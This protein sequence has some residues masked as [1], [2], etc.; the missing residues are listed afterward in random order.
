MLC[1]VYVLYLDL[2]PE[3]M[4]ED[5]IHVVEK[6]TEEGQGHTVEADIQGQGL[7]VMIEEEKEGMLY[8]VY[9]NN[10]NVVCTT[11]NNIFASVS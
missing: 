8:F 10:L 5:H 11:F 6:D 4:K 7:V 3:V 1:S 2:D 9:L